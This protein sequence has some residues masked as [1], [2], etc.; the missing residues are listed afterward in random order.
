MAT[1]NAINGSLAGETGT[2]TY[3]GSTSAT[4]VTPDLGTPSAGVLTSCTGL[5]ISTGVSGLDTGIATWLATASSA[6]LAAAMDDETGTGLLV[7]ATDPVLTTPN[8]GTPSAGVL[9]SCTGLPIS[10]GVSGLAAGIATWL[11]T[12]SSANLITAVTDETGTGLLVFATDPVLTTPNIGTPSA[13]VLTSCTGLPLTTG[14]TGN[15]PVT[16]LNSGTSAS[17]TTFWR[18]DATWAT[19][20]GG[21]LTWN[22]EVTTSATMSANNAYIANNAG[23]VTLTLPDTAALGDI[24]MVQGK[25]AGGWAIAQNAGDTIHFGDVSTTTGVGGSLA[26]NDQYDSIQLVCITANT[27]FAVLTGP[28]GTITYV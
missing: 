8:I 5:P 4:L 15:L 24:V 23:L 16:N 9:T 18:G 12:P 17:G 21:G 27:D 10:T 6:N 7:F 11:A 20:A 14:V 19:P 13:G 22:E 1:K 2:G 25:G 28:Q 26:S 3:V